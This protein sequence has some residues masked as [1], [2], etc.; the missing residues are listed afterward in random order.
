[1]I[2]FFTSP[3][4]LQWLKDLRPRHLD[5]NKPWDAREKELPRDIQKE[6]D[7]L[8]NLLIWLGNYDE[9]TDDTG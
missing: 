7:Y 9:E 8:Q 1:M 4:P 5:F 6:L 3:E 2:E